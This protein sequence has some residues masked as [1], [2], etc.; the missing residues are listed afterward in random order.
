MATATESL[1]LKTTRTA[2]EARCPTHTAGQKAVPAL[3][4]SPIISV[5]K[6]KNRI[7]HRGPY[8]W[9]NCL[10]VKS[11]KKCENDFRLVKIV[12]INVCS[13]FFKEGFL[14]HE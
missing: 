8:N 12:R 4:T 2:N 11:V 9:R 13:V 3:S 5:I 1:T 14:D 6:K 10:Y 7:Y